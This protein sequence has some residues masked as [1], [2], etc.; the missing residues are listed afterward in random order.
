M[1]QAR[2]ALAMRYRHAIRG[3]LGKLLDEH[4]ADE[5]AQ[6]VLV[7]LLQGKFGG[8]DQRKGRFRDYLKITVRNAAMDCLRGKKRAAPLPP[9]L[10]ADEQDC[11]LA[12]WRQTLLRATWDSLQ[13]HQRRQPGSLAFTVLQ[14]AAQHPE[15]NSE[16]LAL[17]LS[18][19]VGRSYRADAVRQQLSRARRRFAR[20]LIAEISKSLDEP[21]PDNVA[22][23]LR[24]LGLTGYLEAVD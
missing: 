2:N 24:D 15:E 3:Y 16:A 7:K 18:E 19:T 12:E 11:W 9:L 14:L 20:L 6:A 1:A 4:D 17:R 13:E 8:V 10:A 5:V 22:D 21:T 23:E